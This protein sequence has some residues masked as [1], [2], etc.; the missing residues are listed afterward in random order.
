M[1]S[2]SINNLYNFF[3]AFDFCRFCVFFLIRF[4]HPRHN[5]Q[6]PPTSK[7][8]LSQILSITFFSYLNSW[9]RDGISIFN[10]EC[11]T[12]EL[13]VPFL[14]HLWYDAVLDWGL[15]PGPPALESSTLPLGYR[16]GC[17]WLGIERWTT[18]TRSQHSTIRLP[19][20]RSLTGD[21]TRDLPH[22][23]PAL[24]H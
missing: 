6:W 22:S 3:L 2:L 17:P 1:N 19:R 4:F 24:Y 11:Q 8:F 23:K 15:N 16:G 10:V 20:R 7:D 5:V 18:R 12:R 9:E 21:W 14:L 13:L